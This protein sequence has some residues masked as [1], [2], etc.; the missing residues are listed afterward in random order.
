MRFLLALP[1]LALLSFFPALADTVA[2]DRMALV[3]G[4][5]N[6][7]TV[8]K[9]RNTINDANAL[10]D[11]LESI[12][13]EVDTLIDAPRAEVEAS[14]KDFAFRA[15][16]ADLA[17]IYFA[18][19]G[20]S[21]QGT[22]FLVPVDA[23][24]TSNKDIVTQAITLDDFLR[25]VD[26]AR[27]M[28]IVILDSCRDNPF[29]DVI[30]LRSPEV[31]EGLTTGKGGLAAPEPGRGTLVAFAAR[32]GEVA[33]D[34][35][36]INSPFNTAL[37]D[38]LVQPGLEISLMFRQVR[39]E[40]LTM[41]DNQ[42]E[43]TTY[44]ALP[45]VPF[46]LAGSDNQ[47]QELSVADLAAAWSKIGPDQT[48]EMIAMAEAGDTRSMF[49]LALNKLNPDTADYD[50]I[51]AAALLEKSAAAGSA[52]A[53][54][55]L[56]RLYERGIGVTEDLDRALQLYQAAAAQNDGDAV[57][58]LGFFYFNGALG[59]PLD[60]AQA[61]KQFQKAADLKQPEAMF[62][63][64][65]F[66][67]DGLVPGLGPKD[68]AGYL[69]QALRSGS[70]KVLEALLEKSNS[71]KLETR[72]ALQAKLAENGLYNGPID[73]DFGPTTRRSIRAAFGILEA[74]N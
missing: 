14:L 55:R 4:M 17:L 24:V 54:F 74:E 70:R 10:A 29:P 37:R 11:T 13:F 26:G 43:P 3:I 67:D 19:H 59:L 27:K 71:F 61:L 5:S 12:G 22:T 68:A 18:G 64:A 33:M 53:Q 15:E 7:Q 62:N 46:Y 6:Y 35:G 40:V 48:S 52:E 2:S 44:G 56:A 20:V 58:E 65:S 66:A 72:K 1:L 32:D 38:N 49:G 51:A 60:Q 45:G 36:G 30:D 57:N 47:R 34:G 21:V 50:P 23:H 39:D 28:R 8:P 42:Q 69:Y 41:T 9:L 63:V 31:A 16:T 25:A 73:G